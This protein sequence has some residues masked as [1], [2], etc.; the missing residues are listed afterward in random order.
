MTAILILA[1]ALAVLAGGRARA[2]SYDPTDFG[3]VGDGRTDCT[4]AFQKALDAAG[5]ARYGVVKVPAGNF[6]FRGTLNLPTGVT[7]EGTRTSVPASNGLRDKGLP[8]PTD[9]GSCLMPCASRG[10]EEGEPFL[11]IGTN[12]T[13]KGFVF[14][15]PEQEHD[16]VPAPYPWTVAMRGKNPALLDCELLN[17]YNGIDAAKNE[18]ALVR[19]ISGQPIRRGI[20]TDEIYDIGRWENIHWNP[21]YSMNT[22]LW[23]WQLENGEAFIFGRSDWHY[24]VNCFCYGY[25][26][27][28]KFIKTPTGT[29]N[30]NFLG[31]G[32]DGCNVSVYIEQCNPMGLLFTNGEFVAMFGKDPVM[33]K[34]SAANK[35]GVAMFDN[36]AF[37]GPCDSNARIKAGSFTFNNC[38]FVDYDCHDLGTPS[39]DV[40]GGDVI[41]SGCRF[42]HKGQAVRLSEGAEALIFKDNVLKTDR[43]IA[44]SSSAQVIEKDNVILK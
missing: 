17:S 24:A 20:F 39:L 21:W 6:L 42:Q 15:Y 38:N 7:L 37:W 35:G 33:V 14:Y 8:L 9:G 3:A 27:G 44:N 28:Y 29:C 11:T 12:G 22:K 10:N 34:A 2:A 31:L 5:E 26:I 1:A 40:S 30:G 36:C 16:E 13:V 4:E 19:N 32:A 43:V 23:K 25:K 18:R 41:V